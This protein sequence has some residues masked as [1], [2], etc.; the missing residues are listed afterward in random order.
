MTPD[1]YID[2][3]GKRYPVFVI[4]IIDQSDEDSAQ[5]METIEVSLSVESLSGVLIDSSGNPNDTEAS[6]IDEDIFFYI[7]D[8]MADKD[9][10]EI[11]D[12]VS[13]NCW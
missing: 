12:F 2:Y 8:E 9:V 7:P 11:A 3:A 6:A 4:N 5:N 13:D 10:S 1:R